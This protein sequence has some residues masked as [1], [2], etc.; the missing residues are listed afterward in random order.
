MKIAI[1]HDVL[2]EF[3]GA[4]RVLQSL[5]RLYPTAHVYTSYKDDAMVRA[6]FPF[7]SKT[8]LFCSPF[9]KI[10]FIQR[11]YLFQFAAPF[12]WK[13][14]DLEQYDV[15]ISSSAYLL[16]NTIEVKHP[17]HIQ[18]IHGPPKNLF[19]IG[20]KT[21]IQ[22]LLPL[23]PLLAHAYRRSLG[24]YGNVAVCSK[25]IQETLRSICGISSEVI[26][27]P[28]VVPTE[29]SRTGVGRYY[30]I[31]SR[32]DASK[33]IEIAIQACNLLQ[34][35]LKIAGSSIDAQYEQHLHRIAGP[36]IEFLGFQDDAQQA[37]LYRHAIAL[38]CT[39]GNEDFGITPVEAMAHGIPVIAYY[40]GGLKETV[41]NKRTGI[42]YFE[43][44]SASLMSV[45]K[46]FDPEKFNPGAIRQ[47]AKKYSEV[48]FHKRIDA[49]IQQA[50][51]SHKE[52]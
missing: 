8:N 49:Y 23:S 37:I 38:I 46:T 3:G 44:S 29:H 41:I 39:A 28:V 16:A 24:Q 30:V 7:L 31:I 13:R 19:H 6:H 18:Y 47:F 2:V 34:V 35:P 11:A 50:L 33:G 36:T 26:Y 45:L 1:I 21:Q 4:E 12:V 9:Q 22:M 5:L 27:P 25:H 43:H 48:N 17:V 20:P 14:L 40:G 51:L 52:R 15:V 32:I 10:P 42:F